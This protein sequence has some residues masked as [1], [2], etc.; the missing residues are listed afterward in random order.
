MQGTPK[1]ER[2]RAHIERMLNRAE[3]RWKQ[4]EAL[5]IRSLLNTLA[6]S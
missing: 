6:S 5:V 4:A 2:E 3:K 1:V